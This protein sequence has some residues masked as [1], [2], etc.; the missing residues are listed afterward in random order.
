MSPIK[1]MAICSY[2]AG[3]Y[4]GSVYAG[5]FFVVKFFDI[6]FDFTRYS[7]KR[8]QATSNRTAWAG[9]S[10]DDHVFA[11]FGVVLDITFSIPADFILI[12][13]NI[14]FLC[15]NYT[16]ILIKGKEFIF[17]LSCSKINLKTRSELLLDIITQSQNNKKVIE[18]APESYT[19]EQ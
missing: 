11:I 7:M 1:I 15:S 9:L 16:Q 10:T 5:A 2:V 14:L 8:S 13:V 18:N 6:G 4:I 17:K 12:V 3:S 19:K